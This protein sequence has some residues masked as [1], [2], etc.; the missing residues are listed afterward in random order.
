MKKI[1]EGK[2]RHQAI[3]SVM[4]RIIN[5]V[6]GILK[7]NKEYIHP[8]QLSDECMDIFN[9]EYEKQ[10]LAKLKSCNK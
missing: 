5:I 2:T 3:N 9:V 6:Y 4:R 7:H 10:K 1:K 8:K